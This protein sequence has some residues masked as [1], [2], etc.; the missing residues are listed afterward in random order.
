[1]PDRV[2]KG[3]ERTAKLVG[4]L[5]RDGGGE[6]GSG[7]REAIAKGTPRGENFTPELRGIRVEVGEIAVREE[8]SRGVVREIRVGDA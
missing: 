5:E 8:Q 6:R 3:R 2:I 4:G 7:G 1:M